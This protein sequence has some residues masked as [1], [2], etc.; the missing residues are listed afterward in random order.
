VNRVLILI[1]IAFANAA[2]GI[3]SA[4]TTS[5]LAVLTIAV[6]LVLIGSASLLVGNMA[7]LLDEFGDELVLTA[8]LE[9][10]LP[11]ARLKDLADR[12]A[13]ETGVVGVEIVTRDEALVRF[14]R[15]AGSAELLEGLA[16][17]PLPPSLEI[18]LAPEARTKAAIEVLERTLEALPGVDELAHGQEWIEGYGRAI[19][20]V[21]GLALGLGGVLGLAALLI[22]ANTIRLAVYARRDEL[23]ILALVGASRTFVRVPFLLEGT[24]QGLLGG[25]LALA[26]LFASYELLL[27]QLQYGLELVLGRAELGFFTTGDAILLVAAGAGLGLLGSITAMIGWRGNA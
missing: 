15:I 3:R 7:S 22:V 23:D 2:R 19:A 17:N 6:V 11:E 25:L 21:R 12:V 26:I 4:S 9:A 5:L 8:Y 18:T 24:I 27:P 13:G 10:D 20:L 14:E 16:E 1:G